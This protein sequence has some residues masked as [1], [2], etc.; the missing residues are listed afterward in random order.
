RAPRRACAAVGLRCRDDV[1]QRGAAVG[2]VTSGGNGRVVL[3]T[4]GARGIGLACARAFEARGDRVA[5]TYRQ[6]PVDDLFSLRCDQT[7]PDEV[8]AAFTAVEERWGPVG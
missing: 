4:G 1:G 7:D 6:K 3:I 5:I 2:P 8:E